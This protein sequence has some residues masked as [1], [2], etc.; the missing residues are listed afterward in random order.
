MP[1]EAYDPSMTQTTQTAPVAGSRTRNAVLSAR[2]AQITHER[3]IVV[4]EGGRVAV[5]RWPG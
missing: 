3:P 5:D 1:P 2:T 4:L